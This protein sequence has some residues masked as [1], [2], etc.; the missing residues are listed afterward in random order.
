M[1]L[2]CRAVPAVIAAC[3][4]Q[5]T[6][7]GAASAAHNH[8]RQALIAPPQTA[9]AC[10]DGA[11]IKNMWLVERLN[12]TYTG[13]ERVQPGNASWTITNTLTNTTERLRCALRA[14]Y[15]CEFNGT[16]GNSSLHIWLQINLDVASFTL[17]Q[18]LPCGS[19]AGTGSAYAVGT[20]QLYLICE[21][22]TIVE[23]RSCYSNDDGSGELDRKHVQDGENEELEI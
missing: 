3:A 20:A 17:N 22:K 11:T 15:L 10:S 9:P 6:T 4:L 14:N 12:V 2:P 16:L 23:G 1:K 19:E 7:G 13:D 8:R 18:S 21:D 5:W